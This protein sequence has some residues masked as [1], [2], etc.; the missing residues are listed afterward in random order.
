MSAERGRGRGRGR[1]GRRERGRGRGRGR[2]RGREGEGE[3]EGERER[4]GEGE[5]EIRSLVGKG[6]QTSLVKC[7]IPSP[8]QEQNDALTEMFGI[9]FRLF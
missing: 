7:V 1:G 4:E 2:E 9:L 8:D 5:R 6:A 3:G